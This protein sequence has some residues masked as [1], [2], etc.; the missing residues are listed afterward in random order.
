MPPFSYFTL[1]LY[2][3]QSNQAYCYKHII[4]GQKKYQGTLFLI[5]KGK[6]GR[7]LTNQKINFRMNEEGGD[8]GLHSCKK[9]CD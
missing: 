1:R 2:V 5:F 8:D 6:Q 7:E 4:M 9:H 3:R